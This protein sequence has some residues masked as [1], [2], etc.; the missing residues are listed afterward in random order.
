MKVSKRNYKNDKTLFSDI[1]YY[2]EEAT[3]ILRIV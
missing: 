1:Q 3:H 2:I